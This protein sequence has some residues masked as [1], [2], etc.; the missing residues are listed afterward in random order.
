MEFL[1][2]FWHDDSVVPNLSG[3]KSGSHMLSTELSNVHVSLASPDAVLTPRRAL[4]VSV[5]K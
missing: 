1:N 4:V 5:S 2:G 3:F